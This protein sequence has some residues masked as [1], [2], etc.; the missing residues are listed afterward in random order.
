MYGWIRNTTVWTY[1]LIAQL[2]NTSD[3]DR[4][5]VKLYRFN[6]D[7]SNWCVGSYSAYIYDLSPNVRNSYQ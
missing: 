1:D 5:G 7:N 4:C 2:E 6:S 3:P